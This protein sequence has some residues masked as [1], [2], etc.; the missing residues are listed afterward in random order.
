MGT[1]TTLLPYDRHTSDIDTLGKY[2]ELRKSYFA[3]SNKH[4]LV[5][6]LTKFLR[7]GYSNKLKEELSRVINFGA[8]STTNVNWLT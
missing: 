1:V 6:T 2:F 3:W 8:F 4:I 5:N 7:V